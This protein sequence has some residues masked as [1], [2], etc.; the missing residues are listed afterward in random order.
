MDFL[1]EA[2]LCC[3][4]LST[5]NLLLLQVPINSDQLVNVKEAVKA[6]I[7]LSVPW[8]ELTEQSFDLAVNEVN[9]SKLSVL[10]FLAGLN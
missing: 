4:A 6:N 5:I 1:T 8:T 10:I 2:R 9:Q 3:I 7:G